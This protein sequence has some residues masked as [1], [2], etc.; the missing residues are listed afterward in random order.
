MK[1]LTYQHYVI[2]RAL[3]DLD[4]TYMEKRVTIRAI[5]E[6]AI[7][8][9]PDAIK[10]DASLIGRLL[11]HLGK[12]NLVEQSTSASDIKVFIIKKEG[13]RRMREIEFGTEKTVDTFSSLSAD[14]EQE[15]VVPNHEDMALVDEYLQYTVKF[16]NA[17]KNL[18]EEQDRLRQKLAENY[19][20][21]EMVEEKLEFMRTIKEHHSKIGGTTIGII[22]AI[23]RD[24]EAITL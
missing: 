18:V 8:T 12:E 22:D 14:Q 6:R 3:F 20:Q 2:L 24:Y 1:Q 19:P 15:A 17:V 13:I 10:N 23:I 21:A 11:N 4:A 7:K 16:G 9:Y 5:H